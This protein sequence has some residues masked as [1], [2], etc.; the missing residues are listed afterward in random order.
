MLL[1]REGDKYGR[2]TIIKEVKAK[3]RSFL[4]CCDCGNKKIIRFSNFR[5]RHTQSCGCLQGERT[6]E[7]N[8]VRGRKFRIIAIQETKKCLVCNKNFNRRENYGGELIESS[9]GFKK[10]NL[11][12][13]SC[14]WKSH[15]GYTPWNKGTKGICKPN[16]GSFKKGDYHFSGAESWNWK[17]GITPEINKIRMSI[18][19]KFWREGNFA[20]DNYTC[21]KCKERGGKL[22]CHH[23]QNFAQYP[24]LR[25]A[26]DNGI[27]FC[28]NCHPEFHRKY[29]IKNNTKEQ[30]GEF[31]N[32][33][34]R[35]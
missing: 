1:I 18:E 2:L 14:V 24:E 27:T 6:G 34:R 5:N 20:R 32:Y 31:L 22:R 33:E 7:S 8:V 12:S 29:G 21:Q 4:C 13:M 9:Y 3:I 25:F 35:N 17:G 10:R 19:M 16:S 11:C 15:T 23:I 28:E 26:I 30:L